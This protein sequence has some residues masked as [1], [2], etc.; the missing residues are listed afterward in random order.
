MLTLG[1]EIQVQTVCRQEGNSPK[2]QSWSGTI[3]LLG[4]MEQMVV[5]TTKYNHRHR[6][7]NKIP[8]WVD[9]CEDNI[10]MGLRYGTR[11]WPG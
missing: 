3:S 6:F 4:K 1:T 2:A 5:M 8:F 9:Q 7:K 10:K 11:V